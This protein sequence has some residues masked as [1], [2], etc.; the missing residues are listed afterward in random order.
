M[1]QHRRDHRRCSC[2]SMRTCDCDGVWLEAHQ[3]SKHLGARYHRNR[4]PIRFDDLGIVVTDG[5]RANYDVR[6]ADI[7]SSVPFEDFN[8][9]VLQA[10]GDTGALEIG[11]GNAE[12]EI[13][14]H[15]SDA[16]HSN[17]A[18]AYKVNVLNS[19]NHYF[20]LALKKHISHIEILFGCVWSFTALHFCGL[21]A[22]LWLSSSIIST[23]AA[24]A[25][26][27]AN[28]RLASS[29]RSSSSGDWTSFSISAAK[30]SPLNSCC[31]IIRA[32]PSASSASA[33]LR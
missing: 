30:R 25:S 1:A 29:M 3:L 31:T 10:I 19:A 18:D 32:A 12:P 24:A 22:F 11:S 7:F 4:A 26:P 33:F 2:F 23:A 13:D 16:G 14:Q 20:C 15:L 27:C 28:L 6:L 17:P 5:S 9:H 8:T 21:F